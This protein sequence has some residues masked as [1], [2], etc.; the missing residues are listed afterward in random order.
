MLDTRSKLLDAAERLFAA[1]GF[2]AVSLR[3][4]IAEADVNVAA[5][6]YHFGS[7][8][9]L[10]DAVVLRKAAAVNEE[11]MARLDR[12]EAESNGRPKV[13]KVLEAFLAP[14][15]EVARSHGAFVQ[16]MGRLQAEGILSGV[17]IRNFQPVLGRF[18][19]LLR[20]C[21]PE[22][23]EPEFRWRV[24][25]SQGAIANAMCGASI[26]VA[27]PIEDEPYPIRIERLITYLGGAFSAPAS[28]QE[29]TLRQSGRS[30]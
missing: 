26:S 2:G 1:Q 11:R 23:S 17:F 15:A 19:G 4:I 18:L 24:H 21:V 25:F 20:K 27:G 7:K 22:M 6:H 14:M 30:R 8:E 10:L 3:Q 9:E 12:V 16:M 13:E 28:R 29:K 5:V